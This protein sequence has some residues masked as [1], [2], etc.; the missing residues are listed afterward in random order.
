MRRLLPLLL[1]VSLALPAAAQR[2][3]ATTPA[4]PLAIPNIEAI[5]ADA[6]KHVPGISIA[7]RKGNSYFAKSWGTFDLDTNA[8]VT[9]DSVFQIA[10]VSKHF[11]AA[12]IMKLV[13]AGKVRVED[14]VRRFI[15]ELDS[16]FDPITIRHLLQ[17]TSGVADYLGQIDTYTET[18]TQAE[19]I[20]LIMNRPPAFPAGSQWQY[21]NAGYYLLGVVIE[22]ASNTPYEQFLRETFFEPLQLRHTTYCGE[23]GPLPEGYG[24][25]PTNGDFF[26]YPPMNMTLIYAAGGLCSSATD[27]IL[28]NRAL[29]NGTALSP[30]SYQAMTS[31]VFNAYIGTRYG[32]GLLMDTLVGHRRIWH[33]GLIFGFQSHVAHFPDDDLTIAVLVNLYSLKDRAGETAEKVARAFLLR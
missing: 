24:S 12:A 2:R 30:A 16:R 7:V 9:S 11:T 33:N 4:T 14:P 21:S 1:I 22:R 6:L 28:W 23:R 29:T 17:H 8:P 19:V 3:R 25:N 31:D 5:A 10:S 20:A 15:P 26:D 13:E 32:Y 18:K 27:L